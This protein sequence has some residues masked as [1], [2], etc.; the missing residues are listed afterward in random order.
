MHKLRQK[1]NDAPVSSL[2]FSGKPL[3]ARLA[4][5]YRC[6]IAAGTL[7]VGERMPSVRM[8]MERHSV[9]L[10]TVLQAVRQLED[11]GWV[12]ARPRTGYFVL[13]A[14]EKSLQKTP[15]P[16]RME[17]ILQAQYV[18][19]HEKISTVIALANTYPDAINLGGATA[20]P[21]LYPAAKLRAISIKLLRSSPTMLTEA[22]RDNGA[23]AFRQAIAKRSLS[24]G[25]NV[26]AD[27]IIVTGGGLE[28]VNLALRAVTQPGDTVAIESPAFFGLLQT[29][30]SLGLRALEIPTSAS[31]GL[32]VEALDV[33]L[34]AYPSV[35]AVVVVPN[36]QNPT[37]SVMPDERKSELV[38][39][40]AV[41]Q[42]PL[43]ED[44][45]YGELLENEGNG[46]SR[47]AAKAWDRDDGVIYCSSLNKVLAPGLRL[48]WI[49]TGR[50]AARIKMLK[51]SQTRHNETLPQLVA[52]DF[53]N[54]GAYDRHL[55]HLR[56]HL[57]LQRA[58]SVEAIKRYFPRETRLTSPVG[59][60]VL[61]LELPGKSGSDAVF[62]TCLAKGVR[63][64]PGTIF[65]NSGRFDS[66]IRLSCP[67]P[68]N[69]ELDKAFK[70]IGQAAS[71]N[72]LP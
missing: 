47:R 70:L 63:I 5:H 13:R 44:D 31:S 38:R 59:G 8:L 62:R 56:S 46:L 15:S 17:P 27:D 3:Y 30:E 39:L 28:A 48:G 53:M 19:L 42:I 69:D 33:A 7:P 51:F 10:S 14:A 16:A 24:A 71:Q 29:L 2:P 23:L 55:R 67:R 22:G 35:K 26:T 12:E 1:V 57:A 36:L 20:A 64:A 4:E 37:G 25:I 50:W 68:F 11:Q 61:W 21:T 40:C 6:V 9:S 43:I 18:G 72:Q 54:S 60:I 66:F 41:R 58:G 34:D 52:A 45:P 65:S 49:S 32:S